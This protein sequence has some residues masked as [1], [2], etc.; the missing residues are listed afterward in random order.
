MVSWIN[1]AERNTTIETILLIYCLQES[2]KRRTTMKFQKFK[3][4]IYWGLTAF[5]VIC[6]SICFYYLL[7]HSSNLWSGVGTILSIAMPILDGFVLAYLLSP[8]LN[9]IEVQFLYPV[10]CTVTH[11]DQNLSNK[12]KKRLR[13]VSILLTM[14]L[15]GFLLYCF[16]SILIP[17]LINSI[18]S[19]IL[20]FPYYIQNLSDW[21]L[22]V[23]ENNPDLEATANIFLERYSPRLEEWVTS[24]LLP[25]INSLLRMVS[26][27]LIGS[28]I[29]VAKALWNLLIG[30]IISIYLLD[31]K[32]N[33]AGQGKKIMYSLLSTDTANV[34]ISN[35]RFIHKTFIGFIGG[36]IVDSIIIGIICYFGTNLMGTPYPVLISVIIGVTNII[37]FFGPYMG[38]IP[39]AILILMVNPPQCLYFIIFI[40]ILQQFDG[41]ILGPKILGDSTGLSSFWVIFS[42]TFFGGLFGVIGMVIGVPVFAVFYAGIRAVTNRRLEEK[43]LPVSTYEYLKVLNIE[44][45][46]TFTK[47]QN[48]PIKQKKKKDEA[49][50]RMGFGDSWLLLKRRSRQERSKEDEQLS[51]DDRDAD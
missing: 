14:L 25:Q 41:N 33:F 39:S 8:L 3:K 15:V 22:H 29:G 35:I 10:F 18:Q 13:K 1:G 34:F 26:T 45:D 47:Y 16:F 12:T 21:I 27:G 44:E 20:Q 37:P 32:E 28:V 6:A 5:F 17:Q 2:D 36:K 42:I 51:A 19:I 43:S 49:E 40:L 4:Y 31:G 23:F 9:H 30:F 11:T 38:A 24:N 50:S 48:N 46:G 7:F